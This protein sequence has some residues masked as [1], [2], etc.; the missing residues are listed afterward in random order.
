MA[1]RHFAA[2]TSPNPDDEHAIARYPK[3]VFEKFQISLNPPRDL[4][5][6]PENGFNQ[7]FLCNRIDI[8]KLSIINQRNALNLNGSN[9]E[10]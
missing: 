3:S 8:P 2:E 10:E 5:R 1:G 6:S 4:E 9:N 7:T